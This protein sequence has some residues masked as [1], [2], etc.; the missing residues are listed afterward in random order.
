MLFY[1]N[2]DCI[3]LLENNIGPEGASKLSE[4]L[5][6]NSTLHTLNLAS[7]IF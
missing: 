2:I 6:K 7:I 1:Y 5:I 4:A 3:T